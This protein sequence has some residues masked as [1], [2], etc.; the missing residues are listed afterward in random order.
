MNIAHQGLRFVAV[1]AGLV[2]VDW[3]VFVALTALG[4]ATAPANVAS[5]AVGAVL[6]FWTNGHVTFGERRAPRL[7]WRRFMRYA[8]AWAAL[9]LLSTV[10]VT[11][12]AEALSLRV[13]WVA[14]PIVEG[15]I[16]VVSF[17]VSRHWVYR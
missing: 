3:A 6:G 13:A 12:V 7:G 16:A 14:K 11:L 15:S 17:F 4:V 1:G 9:T 5:R 2:V 8:V 10:L